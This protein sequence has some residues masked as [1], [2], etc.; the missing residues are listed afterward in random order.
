MRALPQGP[1]QQ[2]WTNQS[3]EVRMCIRGMFDTIAYDIKCVWAMALNYIH[4]S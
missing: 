4:I 1:E 2:P 3:T